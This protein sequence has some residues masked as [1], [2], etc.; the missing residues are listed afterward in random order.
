MSLEI[1]TGTVTIAPG[2]SVAVSTPP[3]GLGT[4]DSVN[5]PS[6]LGHLV[7]TIAANT[8]RKGFFVQNQSAATIQVVLTA[9]G[10]SDTTFVLLAPNVS[11]AGFAGASVDF[12]G[13]PHSGEIQVYATN[14]TD[15]VAARDW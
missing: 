7:I 1:D 10:G 15:Q 3:S 8:S 6:A 11:G 9:A 12:S 4:D 5:K 14:T 13:M 2:S